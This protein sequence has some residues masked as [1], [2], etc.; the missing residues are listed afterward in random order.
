MGKI[1]TL[2]LNSYTSS[3]FL[4]DEAAVNLVTIDQT[5]S[6]SHLFFFPDRKSSDAANAR[7]R[8]MFARRFGNRA[9]E[10]LR[11]AARSKYSTIHLR[12]SLPPLLYLHLLLLLLLFLTSLL[13]PLF[14]LVSTSFPI[15][16]RHL[17]RR[18]FLFVLFRDFS[19]PYVLFSSPHP[20]FLPPPSTNAFL[21]V[22]F[23]RSLFPPARN[24]R[25]SF[26]LLVLSFSFLL[27]L[28]RSLAFSLP[29][30]SR[31]MNSR[32]RVYHRWSDATTSASVRERDH[33][34]VR[35]FHRTVYLSSLS[36]HL[37]SLSLDIWNFV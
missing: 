14:L 23:F 17:L 20:F 30:T 10:L 28:S 4:Q 7:L 13:P 5:C 8:F 24:C 11:V 27:S 33:Q 22:S 1:A 32:G 15:T 26:S 6:F 9:R 29:H 16:P 18:F 36:S 12:R 19:L 31:A 3:I 2:G 37:I 25:L 21:S 34:Y 35:S